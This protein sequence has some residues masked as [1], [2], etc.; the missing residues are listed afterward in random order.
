VTIR[1]ATAEDETAVE[2]LFR[3]QP[4]AFCG[5]IGQLHD[6]RVL[7]MRHLLVLDAPRGGLAAA[8]L[9]TIHGRR[10]HLA[11]LAVDRRFEGE[12]LEDRMI[13]VAEA[14][15]RAYDADTLDVPVRSAK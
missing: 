11:L 13:G 6:P 3:M 4:T 2:H 12:H 1:E 9:V 8:A 15:C 7:G 10:G 5:A 14:L